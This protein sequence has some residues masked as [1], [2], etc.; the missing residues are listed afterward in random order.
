MTT[1]LS[2]VTTD[3]GSLAAGVVLTGLTKT[4]RSAKGPVRAVCSVDL[5]IAAGETVALLGPN[6]AGM[7]T[8]IVMMLGVARRDG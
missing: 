1:S 5:T 8:T 2:P 4:F 3:R 7:W 6:G